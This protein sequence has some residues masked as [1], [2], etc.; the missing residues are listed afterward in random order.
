MIPS[1]VDCTQEQIDRLTDAFRGRTNI[2]GIVSALG[3]SLQNLETCVFDFYTKRRLDTATNDALDKL[4]ALVG[5]TR[6]GLPDADYREA[7]RL[8]I[9]INK[10]D[11]RAVDIV[12]ITNMLLTQVGAS[13][14]YLEGE[15][16]S[17][18][19]EALNATAITTVLRML[20]EA[21]PAGVYA[22]LNYSTWATGADLEWGST[23]SAAAGVNVW[24]ST[25]TTVASAGKWIA[26]Q[27]IP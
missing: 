5:Q 2:E 19:I 18:Q 11:G 14:G 23:T 12:N 7:I 3:A 13:G 17:F 8:R 20:G 21:R 6:D 16:A 15:E 10:S 1:T 27:E 24:G 25:T 26:S 4:G 22:V 9:A